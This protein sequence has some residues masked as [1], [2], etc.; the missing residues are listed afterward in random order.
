VIRLDRLRFGDVVRL[1]VTLRRDAEGAQ[2]LEDVSE[3]VAEGLH[4]YLRM[5]ELD[6]PATALVRVFVTTR[7]ARLD[8]AQ[9]ELIPEEAPESR[10]LA[11]AASAGLESGWN[12]PLD[13]RH[14]RVMALTRLPPMLR[15]ALGDFPQTRSAPGACEGLRLTHI[16]DARDAARIPDQDFVAR[17][18]VRSVAAFTL[19]L[20]PEDLAILVIFAR[21]PL[22]SAE[23]AQLNPLALEVWQTLLRVAGHHRVTQYA[24]PGVPERDDQ[25]IARLNGELGALRTLVRL[26]HDHVEE[27]VGAAMR[28]QA[29]LEA[30]E[31]RLRAML[32]TLPDPI[33]SFG[34]EGSSVGL[35]PAAGSEIEPAEL[36]ATLGELAHLA[37]NSGAPQ[38]LV[39]DEGPKRREFRLVRVDWTEALCLA[40]DVSELS[41]AEHEAAEASQR[42]L[43]ASRSKSEFL[44][45]MS[46]EIRTPLNGVIGL[47][48]LLKR[49]P[50]AGDQIEYVQTAE[51]S[52][53]HLLELVS[54]ILDLSKIEAG[55]VELEKTAICVR[56]VVE[57]AVGLV[58]V[59]AWDKGLELEHEVSPDV[60]EWVQGDALRMRQVLL[61][62]V[63]NA[64]KFSETGAIRVHVSPAGP[65]QIRFSVSDQGAGIAKGACERIFEPF[66]QADQTTSR[67]HGGTG[68]GL[69]LCKRFVELMGGSIGVESELGKGSTFAFVVQAPTASEP[70]RSS[71]KPVETVLQSVV[72]VPLRV[73]VAEDSAVNRLVIT[74]LLGH[75]G[76]GVEVA[77]N[78]REAIEAAAREA[79]DLI[80]MDLEM[81]EVDGLMAT[82]AI[83]KGPNPSVRIVALTAHATPEHIRLCRDASMDDV[84][85]KPID[86]RRLEPVLASSGCTK[87]RDRNGR[88]PLPNAPTPVVPTLEPARPAGPALDRAAAVARLGGDDELWV[89]LVRAARVEAPRLAQALRM[90]LLNEDAE[91]GARS[92]HSLKGALLNIG[93]RIGVDTAHAIE[94]HARSLDWR[95]ARSLVGRLEDE[96][97]QIDNE[98]AYICDQPA[99]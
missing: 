87:A 85:T 50:L 74:R 79:F 51:A 95:E 67:R 29:R 54:D 42:A 30:R 35:G 90:A 72:P 40:R 23:V 70:E 19:R 62:L 83:R 44:A 34:A 33:Y 18:G 36:R 55:A 78:G 8:A 12:S 84:L 93:A 21:V 3:R 16:R 53:H 64:I 94:E 4:R 73:L 26:Q 81:P 46:H 49:T 32:E 57:D 25:T 82:R 56:K 63:G 20:P 89:D 69:A 14:H 91:T 15:V 75:L 52:A 41:R 97:L 76:H 92:A 28:Y 1:G 9:R 43:E 86:V 60:P 77:K 66:R 71:I 6:E 31:R 88:A 80:L 13:S 39:L 59:R 58:A 96:W 65:G 17:A 27:N 24:R 22:G 48:E 37:I 47:L 45:S 10:V 5:G 68:L 11:L 98:L 99:A 7:A 61:N 2:N 38:R